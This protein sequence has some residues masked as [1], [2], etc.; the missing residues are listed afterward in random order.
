MRGGLH[1][2]AG[3]RSGAAHSG[4]SGSI[5]ARNSRRTRELLRIISSLAVRRALVVVALAASFAPRAGAQLVPNARWRT[6]RTEHFRITFTP[7]LIEQARR[8]AINAERAYAGL[9]REL[10][11]PRG[12]IDLVIADN[13]DYVNGYATPFPTNRIVVFAHPA[14]DEQSLRNYSDW[15]ELVVT[16]ELTHI[17]HL[18]RVRGIWR[19][20]QYVFGRNPL[21]FPN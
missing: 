21:L 1:H 10:V 17:F 6:I 4:I 11:P 15:N 14:S 19:L 9:A 5:R 2:P 7:E 16:H 20:G 12:T 18:D 13:A 8:A 3:S